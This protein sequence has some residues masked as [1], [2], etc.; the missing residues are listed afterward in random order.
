MFLKK[1]CLFTF[2]QQAWA[3][4]SRTHDRLF[5]TPH[6]CSRRTIFELQNLCL[7]TLG[8]IQN[9][10]GTWGRGTAK[11]PQGERGM[12]DTSTWNSCFNFPLVFCILFFLKK[13]FS[14]KNDSATTSVC[15]L[16]NSIV[17]STGNS[18]SLLA[19]F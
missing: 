12:L 16:K 2:C 10:R 7:N 9:P 5:R 17:N 19:V 8:A 14:V 13:C 3:I 11:F 15:C 4:S 18:P 6:T 1:L